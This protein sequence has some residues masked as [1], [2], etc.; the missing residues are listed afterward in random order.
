MILYSP[1]DVLDLN[2]FLAEK[3]VLLVFK[4]HPA[5]DL[6]VMKD[7]NCSNIRFIYNDYMLGR[8]IQTNELLAQTDA[9]ITDYSG[10]YY[11]YLL[12]DKPIGVTLDDYEDYKQQ[13]DIDDYRDPSRHGCHPPIE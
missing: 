7:L 10:I 2:G 8:G 9:L 6:S 11:D 3:R 4:P 1:E 12:T 5:Q 13:K